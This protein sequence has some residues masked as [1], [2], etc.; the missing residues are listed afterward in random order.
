[1]SSYY[2][3]DEYIP[4]MYGYILVSLFLCIGFGHIFGPEISSVL[5]FLGA[6]EDNS[7]ARA[8]HFFAPF[9]IYLMILHSLLWLGEISHND[10]KEYERNELS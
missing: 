1:M 8:F 9:V 3:H 5:N 10:K 7:A 4:N 2:D 6:Y